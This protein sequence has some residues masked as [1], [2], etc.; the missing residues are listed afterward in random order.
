MLELEHWSDASDA[1]EDQTVTVVDHLGKA[2]EVIDYE[3]DTPIEELI[4]EML[5]KLMVDA[6]DSKL[7]HSLP[8]GDPC[9]IAIEN[10]LG[11]WGW[12]MYDDRGKPE[13]SA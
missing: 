4:G 9:H 5:L 8:L 3:S 10:Q 6:R 2:H 7:F 11:A 13:T 1:M 12:P